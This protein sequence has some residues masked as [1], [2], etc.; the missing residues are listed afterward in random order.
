MYDVKF[1]ESMRDDEKQVNNR[2]KKK[3]EKKNRHVFEQNPLSCLLS[4]DMC[5]HTPQSLVPEELMLYMGMRTH[6]DSYMTRA[7][8]MK[9]YTA[10]KRIESFK[11]Y[12]I[13]LIIMSSK[14]SVS[15][16][17]EPEEGNLNP[18]TV[19][20]FLYTILFYH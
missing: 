1:L 17:S 7:E 12:L 16:S 19:I 8:C 15:H 10:G 2:G 13:K 3:K 6:N 20:N 4:I 5:L 14:F 11:G 9:M 18:L